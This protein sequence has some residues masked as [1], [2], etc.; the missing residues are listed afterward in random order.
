M[1]EG[2]RKGGGRVEEGSAGVFLKNVKAKDFFGRSQSWM[3][4][5]FHFTGSCPRCRLSSFKGTIG[6]FGF[7]ER[8]EELWQKTSS[9]H[10]AVYYPPPHLCLSFTHLHTLTFTHQRRLAAMQGTNQLIRSNWGL[11]VLLRDTSTR[12]GWES[13]RQ[14]SDCQT[15]ALP[16]ESSH[17]VPHLE[18][19]SSPQIIGCGN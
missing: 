7:E 19:P 9:N 14:P 8:R 11:G 3:K 2:W 5:P 16:P 4:L 6:H 17:P 10:N 15:T 12:P 18:I 13:N 1:E